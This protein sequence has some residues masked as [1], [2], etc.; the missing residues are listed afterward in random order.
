M[1]ER[2]RI[3]LSREP[4]LPETLSVKEARSLYQGTRILMGVTAYDFSRNPSHGI[5]LAIGE[6][7]VTHFIS[8]YN[9]PDGMKY[10]P[11]ECSIVF[12]RSR[13]AM[14]SALAL[15][16]IGPFALEDFS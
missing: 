10:F 4:N 16:A 3:D 7:N 2:I 1:P 8:K 11:F 13:A 15:R 5:V 14:R 9:L 12:P 6:E